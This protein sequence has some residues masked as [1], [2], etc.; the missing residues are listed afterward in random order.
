MALVGFAT[1]TLPTITGGPL[2]NFPV[3][4]KT[5]DFHTNAINGG[6]TSIDN[7]GDNFRM[8]TDS[9]KT[10]RLSVQVERFVTGGSPDVEVYVKVPSAATSG[11][12]YVEADDTWTQPAATAAF[13]SQSVWTDYAYVSHDGGTTDSATG[14]VMVDD[15]SGSV[16]TSPWGAAR[17]APRQR[18]SDATIADLTSNFAVQVWHNGNAGGTLAC[19]RDGTT[20]QWQE[21]IGVGPGDY[22]MAT[23]G[24]TAGTINLGTPGSGW[25]SVTL[26]VTSATDIDH[27]AQG[28]T[29]S[30][31]NNG[32]SITSQAAVPLRIGYR[33]NGGLGTVGNGNGATFGE[34]RVRT[35]TLTSAWINAEFSN[36][37]S[38]VAWVSTTAW[39][40]GGGGSPVKGIRFTWQDE[41]L[42]AGVNLTNIQVAWFDQPLPG[43]FLAPTFTTTTG[44]TNGSGIF[45]IDLDAVTAL[46]IGGTGF[47]IAYDTDAGD[48]KNTLLFAGQ[49]NVMDIQ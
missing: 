45:E 7:G 49:L 48:H 31:A 30:T 39:G 13:G 41:S 32:I 43:N 46:A 28:S 3:L 5:V 4:L 2:T 6:S 40:N 1:L 34:V 10:T 25:R 47:L 22:F 44:T 36:Q 33:G 24:V 42:V 19:R 20:H 16:S 26:N 11:T 37:N 18:C 12:I 15:G 9:S 21:F 29:T 17:I 35:S 27:Y 14:A 8:Y 38:S 23:T